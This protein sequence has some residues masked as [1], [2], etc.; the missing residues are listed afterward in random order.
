M[1]GVSVRGGAVAAPLQPPFRFGRELS[2]RVLGFVM[3]I[4]TLVT[5]ALVLAYPIF[6]A[7]YLSF[8]RVSLADLRRG[9]F[10]FVGLGNYER[11]LADPL[12]LLAL[13]NTLIFTA[14]SVT[15]EV[16]LA[17][18]IALLI[19]QRQVW[20]GRITK[21]LI[22]L[23]YA[24]PPIANGLI[25]SFMYNFDFGFLNRILFTLGMIHD[26]INW[27]GNPDT[28]LIAVAIP[29]IW[30][31]LPFAILLVHAALQGINPELYEAA[32]VDGAG[33]LQRFWH[34]T[35]PLLRPIIV[36]TLVLRT[37]FA[38]AVFDEIL[39]ITQG[40]PGDATWV[41]AWYSYRKGFAPPFD[42][43]VGSASAYVLALIVGVLAIAYVKLIYR[44]IQ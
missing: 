24:V 34:I 44:R 29:Y 22:L 11:I 30:R 39:A 6:Y 8:H 16:V 37:S 19:D 7:A 26:P 40:G 3:N 32:S 23:P 17:I 20:T 42:I 4:P 10:P 36:V 27:A 2:A 9:V 15:A 1:T 31:T 18:A 28:A 25:W 13:K 41:A 14:I 35:L 21:F 12:F 43:G 38:F 33:A 5:L